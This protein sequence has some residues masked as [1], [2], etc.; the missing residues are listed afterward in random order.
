MLQEYNTSCRG[1]NETLCQVTLIFNIL[2]VIVFMQGYFESSKLHF[3]TLR[4][5]FCNLHKKFF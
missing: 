1:K 4:S 2:F 3:L 5:R